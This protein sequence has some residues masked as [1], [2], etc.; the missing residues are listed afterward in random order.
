[1]I[2]MQINIY[3][4]NV[5]KYNEG[6]LIGEWIELPTDHDHLEECIQDVLGCDEEY[7]IHDYEAPFDVSEYENVYALN[8]FVQSLSAYDSS[9]VEVLYECLGD[10]E[11]MMRVLSSGD[12]S[13]YYDVDELSDVAMQMIDEGMYGTVPTSLA[14]YIDYDK[15]ARNLE[16]KGWY[17]SRHQKIALYIYS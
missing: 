17:F 8:A 15:F 13:V 6:E 14:P 16:A 3:V 11:E 4:A 1:M 12:Y 9:L 10:R 7:A 5:A 2:N